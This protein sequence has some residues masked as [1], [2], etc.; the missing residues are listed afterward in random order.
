MCRSEGREIENDRERGRGLKMDLT[1]LFQL[2]KL[3]RT[4]INMEKKR[5]ESTVKRNQPVKMKREKKAI[6]NQ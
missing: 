3:S 1:G 6:Y 4:H 2:R 5:V